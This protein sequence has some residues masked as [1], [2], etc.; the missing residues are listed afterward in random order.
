L[1]DELLL[2][3]FEESVMELVLL[4][5]AHADE[6]IFRPDAPLLL[7]L[8]VQVYEVQEAAMASIAGAGAGAAVALLVN[9]SWC[10]HDC[11]LIT[12][13]ERCRFVCVA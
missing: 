13:H 2:L 9:Q 5:A 1:Q 12:Q 7:D 6:R 8:L 10:S 11:L 3:L 4:V